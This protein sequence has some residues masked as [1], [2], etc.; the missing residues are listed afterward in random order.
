MVTMGSY[1][2]IIPL[3]AMND[4]WSFI[5]PF[6]TDLWIFSIIS[7]PFITLVMAVT[8]YLQGAKIDWA[9]LAGFV[10]R[11]ILSENMTKIPDKCN[12][13]KILTCIW[14]LVSFTQQAGR[15]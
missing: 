7:I 14:M 13:Q 4:V 3:N 8:D 2:I 6:T 5:N 11:N 12:H 1:D 15:R 10:L 9:T